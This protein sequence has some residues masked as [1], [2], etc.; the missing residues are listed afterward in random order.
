MS[1]KSICFVLTSPFAANAFLLGHLKALAN[2]FKVT[3]CL[4]RAVYPLSDRIDPRVRVVDMPIARKISLFQD[5]RGL[6]ALMRFF[7]SE[8]FDAVHSITPKAGLLAMLA[9]ALSGVPLRYHT[10]T[11]QVWATKLGWRRVL[12]KNIDRFIVA[13]ATRVFCDSRSQSRF[14]ESEGVGSQG[15][16]AILGAGSIAGVD[17]T[18]FRPDAEARR[19]IRSEF[20]IPEEI[21]VFLYVGRIARDKGVF[22]LIEAFSALSSRR[23]DVALLMVGP[24]EEHLQAA[25]QSAAG[26]AG[27]KIRWLGQSFEPERFMAAADVLMLP[28]YREGF[29]MVVI[30]AASCGLPT[31][32]Y[33]IDGVID[34]V[35]DGETGVLL[36]IGDVENL[37]AAMEQ[38]ADDP[39][40]RNRL[41]ASARARVLNEF[42]DITVTSAWVAFYR[43]ATSS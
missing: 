43:Q 16:V 5:L 21:C 36:G 40:L 7:R 9:G 31:L 35:V 27:S 19:R 29:G 42:L 14:L 24:D 32:A 3:L 2:H 12:F 15:A 39:M 10:F 34:A 25:L 20:D 23:E 1:L 41:G 30:E 22:D 8:K 28:S 11:G 33:R 18:R 26:T 37:V 17:P 4:N 13:C 6:L 38:M